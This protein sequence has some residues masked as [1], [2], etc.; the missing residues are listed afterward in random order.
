MAGL[1]LHHKDLKWRH[2]ALVPQFYG[3]GNVVG[4]C[5]R[6]IYFESAEEGGTHCRQR[7]DVD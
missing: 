7:G 3:G 4:V 6:F 2:I 5:A 1:G